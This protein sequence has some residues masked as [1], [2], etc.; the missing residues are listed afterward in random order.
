MTPDRIT[1]LVL[2]EGLTIKDLLDVVIELNGI[3][4][5]GLITLSD[6]ITKHIK[7]KIR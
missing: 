6:D 4:G 7:S 5:V 3:I 2:D 1:K